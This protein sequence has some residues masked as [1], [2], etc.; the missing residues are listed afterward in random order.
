MMTDEDRTKWFHS[1]EQ[2][3]DSV[4]AAISDFDETSNPCPTCTGTRTHQAYNNPFLYAAHG[5]FEARA[6]ARTGRSR[7]AHAQEP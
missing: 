3:L 2:S 1:G 4:I 6:G 5:G 7:P